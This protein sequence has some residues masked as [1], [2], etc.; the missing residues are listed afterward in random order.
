MKKKLFEFTKRNII[1]FAIYLLIFVVTLIMLL[2]KAEKEDFTTSESSALESIIDGI[3]SDVECRQYFEVPKN[4]NLQFI[5]IQFATYYD[6]VETEGVIFTLYTE[7]GVSQYSTK[8]K[9]KDLQDNAYYSVV[10]DKTIKNREGKYY[11]EIKGIDRHSEKRTPAIWTSDYEGVNTG[12]YIN[13]EQQDYSMN[14]IYKYS[15]INYSLYNHLALQF[16]LCFLLSFISL[17]MITGKRFFIVIHI[18][19]FLLNVVFIEWLTRN[20]GMSG[21]HISFQIKCMTYILMLSVQLMIFGICQNIHLSVILVDLFFAL[22]AVV[23]Y[24]V[25][26]YRGSTIVPSDIFAI[27]TL[28]NVVDNYPIIF[29]CSQIILLLWLLLWIK[30]N[31]RLM[32]EDKFHLNWSKNRNII[33]KKV[34]S[35]LLSVLVSGFVIFKF[36]DPQILEATGITY[37]VWDRNQGYY[38][39]GPFMN[40]MANVQYAFIQKPEA[41]TEEKAKEYLKKYQEKESAE[42]EKIKPHIIM[43][44][45]ESL[46]DFNTYE[47]NDVKFSTDPLPFIHSLEENTIKGRCYVSVFGGVTANSEIEALTGHTM[48]FFPLGSVVYQQFARQSISGI[49]SSLNQLGY[50][51]IAVHPCE[52]SNWNRNRVY[53]SMG[54]EQFYTES[55]FDDPEMVRWVSDKATYDMIIDLYEEKEAGETLFIFDVTMQ[56]HGGYNTGIPWDEPVT[57]ENGSYPY[58]EE[59]LSSSYVSGQAFEYLVNYFANQDEPVLIFMFGD[60]QP[61]LENGFYEQLLGKSLNDLNLEESQR[62]YVTPYV[63]WTNYE[64]ETD[65]DRTISTNQ[66][67]GLIKTS[68][69]LRLNSY[70]KFIQNFSKTI[71]VI[72]GNGYMDKE[73]V[74]YNFEQESKYHNLLNQ[75]EIIQY[76]VYWDGIS[77]E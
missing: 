46:A 29:N 6:T 37:Y 21:I 20:I 59:Y 18:A 33:L 39:N 56:G 47:N 24:F 1:V 34:I 2:H 67:T 68:A 71:P 5:S 74:W 52:G 72:N 48:A 19:V 9:S 22:A 38:T 60:H 77:I 13:G 62:R 64:I 43:I 42:T 70:E 14:V 26:L 23:N 55:D 57:V 30:L 65:N 54:F 17:K 10:F 50:H 32:R 73:G 41:Y 45:N 61:S 76:G 4:S 7:N 35:S 15:Q 40:F 8:I 66:I 69:G 58:A 11:F 31:W 12:L 3:Y 28:A 36:C 51:S 16:L 27:G 63:L 25:M 49:A 53:E 75:Y 44:M